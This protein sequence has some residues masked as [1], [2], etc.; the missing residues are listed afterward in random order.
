M[1]SKIFI[2]FLLFSA[3][4][5]AQETKN[6]YLMKNGKVTHKVPVADVDS[7][8]FY[9]PE[10]TELDF[11]LINGV[12]WATRNV[13][14]PGTFAANPEDVG[15]FY[16]W[17]RTKGWSAIGT[18]TGWDSSMPTGTT[19]ETT[20]NVC[21]TGYRVP[22]DAEIQSLITAGSLWTTQNGVNGRVF[23]SGDNIIFLP[24][25]GFR[26]LSNGVL[27]IAGIFGYYW[28]S[29]P[30]GTTDAYYFSFYSGLADGSYHYRN[31]GFSVRCVVD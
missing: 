12:K 23:G 17:N 19:W 31:Y 27:D 9:E 1:K 21:P 11:V 25:A 22:T 5:F 3:I 4:M 28:S 10:L 6:I 30:R 29:T 15:M 16:Q 20:N 2:L 26:N 8:I 13:D 7:I 24:A 14:A 18:V